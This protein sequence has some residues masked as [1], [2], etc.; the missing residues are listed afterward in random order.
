MS[1]SAYKVINIDDLPE[2]LEHEPV[3]AIK[4]AMNKIPY[5]WMSWDS[6][7]SMKIE[8]MNLI[9]EIEGKVEEDYFIELSDDDAHIVLSKI[10]PEIIEYYWN[11]FNNDEPNNYL[12]DL[13]N[14]LKTDNI[15]KELDYIFYRFC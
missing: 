5:Q 8:A 2:E 1:Y 7:D 6:F 12:N 9:D 13:F 10:T 3:K 4:E 14:W 11:T 15:L